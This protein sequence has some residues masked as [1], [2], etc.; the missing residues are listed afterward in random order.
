MS[1]IEYGLGGF[2]DLR[3]KKG[4]LNFTGAWWNG[5]AVAFVGLPA[6]EP[7]RFSLPACFATRP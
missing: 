3:L 1:R 2:G 7:V 4:G 6:R 5:L